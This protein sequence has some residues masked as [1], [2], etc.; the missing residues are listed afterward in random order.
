MKYSK[1]LK[2]LMPEGWVETVLSDIANITM[3]QSP[4]GESYNEAGEGEVFY[5]GSTDF[6]N[7]F[8]TPRVYTTAPSRFAK[9]GD[10]LMSVRA[11]V[12]TL[13]IAMEDCCIG[14]GLSALNSKSGSQLHLLYVLT[15][16]KMRFDAMNSNGT[17]FGSINKDQLY[18]L[19]VVAPP[20]DVL[21]RFE[22]IVGPIEKKIQICETQ[23]RCLAKLRD[24]LLP[25]LMNGQAKIM[26]AKKEE[27]Q[28]VQETAASTDDLRFENWL[29]IMGLA[30]RGTVDRQTLH[31]IFNAMDEDDKQ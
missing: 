19:P 11:P 13:N 8:P 9:K 12:G 24:W 29:N 1:T 17:T 7:R 23:N 16:Y 31:D 2:S 5:Q 21:K 14:R 3:G 15:D 10:V 30:A 25:M 28:I 18:A 6:G 20:G 22:A 4:S 26:D 27:S